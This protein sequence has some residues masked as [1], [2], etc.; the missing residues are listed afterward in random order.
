MA[1][2]ACTSGGGEGGRRRIKAPSERAPRRVGGAARTCASP[3]Q[4]TCTATVLPPPHLRMLFLPS[5]STRRLGQ[6]CT[7]SMAS[8]RL[9]VMSSSTRWWKLPSARKDLIRLCWYVSSRRF[10]SSCNDGRG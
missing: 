3:G 10:S 8:M 1:Q 7:P 4:L 9:S 2:K 6:P 5:M